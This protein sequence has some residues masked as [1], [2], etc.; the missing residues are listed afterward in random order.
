[1]VFILQVKN[2]CS[3]RLKIA[4]STFLRYLTVTKLKPFSG[5]ARQCFESLLYEANFVRRF[6]EHRLLRFFYILRQ[7]LLRF[8]NISNVL[9][10]C[11]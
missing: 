6:L 9:N 1:M 8:L 3:E 10:I 7:F 5:K 2:E 11:I 4:F